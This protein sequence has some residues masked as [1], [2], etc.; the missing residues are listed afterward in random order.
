MGAQRADPAGNFGWCRVV[1]WCFGTRCV[2]RSRYSL[3]VGLVVAVY[4]YP[5]QDSATQCCAESFAHRGNRHR[6]GSGT[7]LVAMILTGGRT[8]QHNTD[9]LLANNY[10]VDIYAQLT[11]VDASDT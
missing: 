10:P 11:Q 6:T 2:I 4:R 5:R 7:A 8:A 1:Y 3:R 9:E